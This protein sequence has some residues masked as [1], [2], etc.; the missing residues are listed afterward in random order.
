MD[1]MKT[2]TTALSLGLAASCLTQAAP[3]QSVST[4]VSP[5][6]EIK[7][8]ENGVSLLSAPEDGK[9]YK[10]AVSYAWKPVDQTVPADTNAIRFEAKGDGSKFLGSV[11]LG[12]NKQLLNQYEATFSLSSTDWQSVTIPLSDFSRADKP[13]GVN[14]PMG[15]DSVFISKEKAKFIGFGRGFQFHKFAYPNYSFS[16]R[17]LEFIKAEL[18]KPAKIQG[19]L[20]NLKKKLEAGD[21]VNVL[22][23]GD[24]I[25]YYGQDKSHG[26]YAFEELKNQYKS[27][28]TVHN[29]AIGGHSVRGG[30]IILDRN[31]AVMPKP[32]LVFAFY[33]ANDCKT[34]EN[35]EHQF[36]AKVFEMQLEALLQAVSDKT[37]GAPEFL[38]INGVPRCDKESM[39]TRG[40]VEPLMPAYTNLSKK[41]DITL[42]DSMSVF[43]KLSKEEKQKYYKDTI[44]QNDTGLQFIGSLVADKLKQE[45]K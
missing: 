33:G 4:K 35:P 9:K 26:F 17:N 11:F 7:S 28:V 21:D 29:G 23:L 16:I 10:Q 13:W 41:Y 18:P 42:V 40:I 3:Y 1:T 12:S 32:D 45:L 44:H 30:K 5:A 8:L 20:N 31:L 36:T 22:L 39:E 6:L 38:L 37:Q 19:G 14:H 27:K 24:S 25:T 34:L 43:L 15:E 2:S